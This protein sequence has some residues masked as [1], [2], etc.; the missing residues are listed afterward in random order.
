MEWEIAQIRTNP[1]FDGLLVPLCY[2]RNGEHTKFYPCG[3]NN[4]YKAE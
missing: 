4:T 2:C 1:K 3:Y